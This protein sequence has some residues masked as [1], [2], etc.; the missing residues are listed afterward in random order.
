MGASFRAAFQ[1][2]LVMPRGNLP[3]DPCTHVRVRVSL[4][5]SRCLAD[6]PTPTPYGERNES[7]IR[8]HGAFTTD[9][10]KT[11]L[12]NMTADRLAPRCNPS[13]SEVFS[14]PLRVRRF[15]D[16]HVQ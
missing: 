7:C 12:C 16:R 2:P 15:K 5:L 9:G 14:W 11:V 8:L 3:A 1:K 6:G 10:M 13:V 4:F